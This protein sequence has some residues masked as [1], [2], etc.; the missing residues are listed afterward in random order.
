MK[1]A[2]TTRRV[3]IVQMRCAEDP[4]TNIEHA[5]AMT[6]TAAERDAEI[7]CLPELF[8][9]RSFCQSEDVKFFELAEPVPGPTSDAFVGLAGF[10]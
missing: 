6:R 7:V 8:R 5:L 10:S 9:S 2:T 3:G 1:R 4:R